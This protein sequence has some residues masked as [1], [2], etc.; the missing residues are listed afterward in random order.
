MALQRE[1]GPWSALLITVGAMIGSG[2]FATP[3]DVAQTVQSPGL[4]LLLWV[5]GGV[6]ALLGALSF[7]ELG[8]AIP[9]TGGLYVYL[10]RAYGRPAGFVFAWA[11][12]VVMVPSSLGF[13]AQVTA[14]HA[15][16]L[17]GIAASWDLPV[18]LTVLAVLV[19][20]N[21]R[22][23][24]SGAA[25]Q[26][27]ATVIK[28]GGVLGVA[29]L[30]WCF[31]PTPVPAAV[32]AP[33][34]PVGLILAALVPVL[35]AYDGWIDITSIAGEVRNPQRDVPRSLAVGTLMVIGL[36]LLANV[37]YLR[38]LGPAGLAA[39]A[40]PA[41][42]AAARLLGPAGHVVVS[43]LI[44]VSTLGGCAVAL[45]T[46]SRVVYAVAA[47]GLFFKAFAHTSAR[48]VPDVAV[49]ACGLLAVLYL[50]S[51][52]GRLGDLF[53]IGAWPFYALGAV[54]T[55]VLR[56]R[57]PDLARPVRTLAF[58][59]P[60][61]VFAAAAVA[62]VLSYGLTYPWQTMLSFGLIGLGLPVYLAFRA[63]RQAA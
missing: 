36:Y 48:H 55:I 6:L 10:H 62:I 12:L 7:V 25:V 41:A 59:L 44:G 60:I 24:Q 17:F 5:V 26:N 35:W 29:M 13:F 19:A 50:V 23:V 20:A 39:S 45:L 15:N 27:L 33:D 22:G 52:V 37:T 18:A 30:G 3:H 11:M 51:P 4:T 31:A 38:V 9:E 53:V 63:L 57:E 2:I 43:L 1:I 42:D 16:S 40:T 47:D 56:R 28:Y 46:G 8:A 54:A 34:V 14:R 21:L 61:V 58:P 32:P 49:S